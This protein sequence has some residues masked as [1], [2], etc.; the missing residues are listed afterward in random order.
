MRRGALLPRLGALATVAASTAFGSPARAEAPD[1]ERYALRA[2][3]GVE[4]DSNAHRTELV[5]GALNPP[6]VASAVERL[7]LGG[8]LSDAVADG[9]TVAL[10][11]TLAGKL[12]DS[13]AAG[14]EDVAIAQSSAGWQAALGPRTTLALGGAYYEAFQ[15]ASTDLTDASERRDFQ[16]L[17]PGAQLGWALGDRLDLTAGAGARWFVFKPDGDDDF[18]APTASLE[19]RWARPIE[20]G[21]DWEAGAGAAFEHRSFGGPAL[22]DTC[23][24][25]VPTGFACSGPET[26]VDEFLM[27]HFDVT[28]TGRV[29]LGAS[30]ALHVNRS[31]SYGE[32]VVRHILGA[33]FATALPAGL[34]LAARAELLLASYAD[35]VIVGQLSA[36]SMFVSIEDE[37]RSNARVDLSRD[38]DE[39]LRLVA[40]A[41]F[42]ANELANAAPISYRRLTL[43][44]SLAYALER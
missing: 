7:V 19:L 13:A 23:P 1:T 27:S 11:A 5:A 4:Y 30:Y 32:T 2:E 31:N 37:N 25:P 34:M 9:Q 8:T 15:R 12:F 10:S 16:S 36:G 35:R 40:R 33:R 43:L 44:L 3:L 39:R 6:V 18:F 42:Y 41:T 29:L 22:T 38:L 14:D 20:G 21:A 24:P 28:R 17:A 26:R